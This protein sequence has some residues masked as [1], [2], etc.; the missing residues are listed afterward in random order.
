[1]GERQEGV[2]VGGKEPPIMESLERP[3]RFICGNKELLG[4]W[5]QL[6]HIQK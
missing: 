2:Q 4:D 6:R 1:M 5:E 3:G